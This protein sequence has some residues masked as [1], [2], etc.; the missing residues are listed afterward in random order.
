MVPHTDILALAD[1]PGGVRV[2]L[3]QPSKDKEGGAPRTRPANDR[4]QAQ[5]LTLW[6]IEAARTGNKTQAL[7]VLDHCEKLWV[8]LQEPKK[9]FDVRTL[10]R[11]LA[12]PDR[13]ELYLPEIISPDT[14]NPTH[15]RHDDGCDGEGD[16][17]GVGSGDD[18]VDR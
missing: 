3:L 14:I 13:P 1:T 2:E 6:A 5:T 18:D 10:K 7:A 15:T 4:F 8:A 9:A 16:A 17:G 11:M 12:N